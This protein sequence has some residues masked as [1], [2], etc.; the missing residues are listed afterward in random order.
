MKFLLDLAIRK[1]LLIDQ[2]RNFYCFCRVFYF[3]KIL[4]KMKEFENVSKDT[5]KNTLA[6]NKRAV[7]NKNIDLPKHPNAKRYFDIGKTLDGS[8]QNGC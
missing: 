5:W 2:I 7:Y 8:K 3:C 4:N 1:V 6:S